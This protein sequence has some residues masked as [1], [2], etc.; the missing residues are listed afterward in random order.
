[1]DELLHQVISE[2]KRL[3]EL[4]REAGYESFVRLVGL[5]DQ[6]IEAMRGRELTDGQREKLRELQACESVLLGHMQDLKREA[7]E[8]LRSIRAS[9]IQQRA[10][11]AK[12]PTESM[13]FDR[14]S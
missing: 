8:R 5:R 2:S 11:Q 13:L 4:G 10:Y 3:S 1:M 7:E 12:A 6:L 14:R 9:K